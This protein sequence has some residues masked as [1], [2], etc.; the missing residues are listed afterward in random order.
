MFCSLLIVGL[1]P[2]PVLLVVLYFF[3]LRGAK[4]LILISMKDFICNGANQGS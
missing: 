1:F 2:L 3:S 4:H